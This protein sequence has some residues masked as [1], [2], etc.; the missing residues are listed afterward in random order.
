M[1]SRRERDELA[2]RPTR[3]IQSFRRLPACGE[4]IRSWTHDVAKGTHRSIGGSRPLHEDRFNTQRGGILSFSGSYTTSRRPV[5]RITEEWRGGY[6]AGP[7]QFTDYPI[8]LRCRSHWAY[9]LAA[10]RDD[11]RI[12]P[13]LTVNL[14]SDTTFPAYHE[15]QD[16]TRTD[17]ATGT[18]LLPESSRSSRI[19][20]CR[21]AL[22]RPAGLTCHSI[23]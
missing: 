5:G 21:M 15:N 11:W 18:R 3:P 17:L 10:S 6:A 22:F 14:E 8:R 2:P 4:T 13:K 20:G 19:P 9:T 12:A 1:D 23:R 16:R 7:R